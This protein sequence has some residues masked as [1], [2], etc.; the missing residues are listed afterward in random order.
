MFFGLNDYK[1]Y[2]FDPAAPQEYTAW[3][4]H[5]SELIYWGA[6]MV[7][8]MIYVIDNYGELR[9]IDAV[10]TYKNYLVGQV[11]CSMSDLA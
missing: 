11:G 3:I 4:E 2:Q 7:D 10:E 8:N 6:T 5:D 1:W 9:I